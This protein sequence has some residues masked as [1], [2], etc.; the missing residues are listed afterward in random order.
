MALINVYVHVLLLYQTYVVQVIPNDEPWPS[1]TLSDERLCVYILPRQYYHRIAH[2]IF[3]CSTVNIASI[4]LNHTILLL[5]ISKKGKSVSRDRQEST[6]HIHSLDI[7]KPLK[8]LNVWNK[9]VIKSIE[10]EHWMVDKSNEKKDKNQHTN[11]STQSTALRSSWA[12]KL[13]FWN[14]KNRKKYWN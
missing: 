6:K 8:M 14:I 2:I 5:F 7:N 9:N 1:V 13:S 12:R 4:A 11:I 10:R 3:G